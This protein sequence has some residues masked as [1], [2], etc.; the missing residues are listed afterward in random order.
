MLSEG[1]KE[2]TQIPG[3]TVR[4]ISIGLLLENENK[5]APKPYTQYIAE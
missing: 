1:S 2:H 3:L 5:H 4:H